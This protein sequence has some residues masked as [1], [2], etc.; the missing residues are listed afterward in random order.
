MFQQ[1][2]KLFLH[3]DYGTCCKPC[4]CIA[5][6]LSD[7]CRQLLPLF[8]DLHVRFARFIDFAIVIEQAQIVRASL[9]ILVKPSEALH[10]RSAIARF[11]AKGYLQ[12]SRHK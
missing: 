2:H 4:S 12:Y 7:L 5:R 1:R 3:Q 9:S 8:A 11:D 6:I 10:H